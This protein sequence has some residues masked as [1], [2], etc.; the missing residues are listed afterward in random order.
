MGEEAVCSIC[1]A[2]FQPSA[3]ELLRHHQPLD[4]SA[5]LFH[6]TGRAA[7]AVQRLKYERATSLGPFMSGLLLQGAE[8]MNLLGVDAVVAVPIHWTRRCYR[9]FNQSELLAERLP[10]RADLL[11]R[12]K[13]TRPQVGLKVAER[14]TN[15]ENAFACV[16]RVEGLRVLLV[17]DVL[18]SG[19]TAREC[20]RALKAAGA[21]E[22]G[23]L[24]FAAGEG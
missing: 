1:F 24:T 3:S 20:A 19:G 4:Y 15:L 22:V 14:L 16:A 9:G 2:S 17:D 13:A 6:Y 11:R 8:R 10:H 18:T 21:A 12:R 5:S 23:V 7:Q